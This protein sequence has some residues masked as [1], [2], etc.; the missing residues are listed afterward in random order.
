MG[1]VGQQ[2]QASLAPKMDLQPLGKC[3]REDKGEVAKG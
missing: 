3:P 2:A 1:S